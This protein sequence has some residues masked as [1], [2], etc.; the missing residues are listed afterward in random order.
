[1]VPADGEAMLNEMRSIRENPQSFI[2]DES[3]SYICNKWQ[4]YLK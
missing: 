1:M 4:G 3:L 2:M